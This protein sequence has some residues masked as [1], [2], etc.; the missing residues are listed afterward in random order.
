MLHPIT[1]SIPKQKIVKSA[2]EKKR[3]MSPL[4]P[5]KMDTYIYNTEED[6]Y[7]QYQESYFA[8][9]MRKSGWDCMRHY[10]IIANGC[11]PYFPNIEHCPIRTMVPLRSMYL[12][13]NALFNK[14]ANKE[15]TIEDFQEYMSVRSEFLSLLEEKLTSDRVAQ[16]I[17]DTVGS[18]G[19]KILWLSGITVPDYLNT[20]TLIGFK[21]LFGKNCHDYPKIPSIYKSKD[22]VYNKLSGK[23]FSYSNIF[24]QEQR[25]DEKDKTIEED[26]KN[27]FYDIVIYGDYHRGTPLYDLVFSVYQPKDVVMLCGQDLHNCNN[28][29]WLD[30]GHHVFVREL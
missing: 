4:I 5:G 6:Y 24:E 16:Y 20:L 10:E 11:V 28:K 2:I 29:I 18:K 15:L 21:E 1:F 22:I 12:K 14:I 3:K 19:T 26:I 7:R 17:L 23:G 27:K 25:D 8:L 30:K 9:T 13:G